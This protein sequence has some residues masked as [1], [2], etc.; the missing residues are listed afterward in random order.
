MP[1]RIKYVF[2]VHLVSN[3]EFDL[4][5]MLKVSDAFD[6]YEVEKNMHEKLIVDVKRVDRS[7]V[8]LRITPKDTMSYPEI[9]KYLKDILN[10]VKSKTGIQ[11]EVVRIDWNVSEFGIASRV[12]EFNIENILDIIKKSRG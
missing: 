4:T 5:E 8:V 10:F 12:G 6:I 11:L 9:G 1:V 7:S 2:D 3:R